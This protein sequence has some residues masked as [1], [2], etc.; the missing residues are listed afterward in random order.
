ML[1]WQYPFLASQNKEATMS[2]NYYTFVL[3]LLVAFVAVSTAGWFIAG[4][5]DKKYGTQAEKKNA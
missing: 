3:S 1:S 4:H 2:L 5:L